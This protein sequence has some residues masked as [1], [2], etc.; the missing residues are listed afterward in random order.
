MSDKFYFEMDLDELTPEIIL[1][2]VA[3]ALERD[4]L[5]MKKIGERKYRYES[6][7]KEYR[8][9]ITFK[10]RTLKRGSSSKP[11]IKINISDEIFQKWKILHKERKKNFHTKEYREKEKGFLETANKNVSGS[12]DISFGTYGLIEVGMALIFDRKDFEKDA[13]EEDWLKEYLKDYS[14]KINYKTEKGNVSEEI[15]KEKVSVG[16][17]ALTIN[18]NEIMLYPSNVFVGKVMFQSDLIKEELARL[19]K[20]INPKRAYIA[21]EVDGKPILILWQ[22]K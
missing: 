19:C 5:D 8:Y 10:G 7:K 20:A 3:W 15:E 17:L 16:S 21:H 9:E 2:A 4:S 13:G 14:Y 22:R 18:L 1:E 12:P 6:S 11:P